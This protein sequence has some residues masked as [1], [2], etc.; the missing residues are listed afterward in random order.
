MIQAISAIGGN[1]NFNDP[2]YM[3]IIQELFKLG[4]APTGEKNVDKARLEAEK[5]KLAEQIQEKAQQ[6]NP[7]Q[8]QEM[9][10]RSKLE[11]EKLG[12]MT[13]AE[14]NKILHGLV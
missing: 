10:Q 8:A 2:E 1:S 5:K 11:E 7:Q 6:V 14:L 12:A 13:V 9:A 3:K 4:I